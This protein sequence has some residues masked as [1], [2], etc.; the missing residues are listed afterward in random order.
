MS[1]RGTTALLALG[2]LLLFLV[3]MFGGRSGGGGGAEPARPTSVEPAGNGYSVARAWLEAQG[4]GVLS[5]RHSFDALERVA[6][7]LPADAGASL[8][9]L[10]LPGTMPIQTHE[11]AP[12]ERW[13]R[14]GNT[15][16]VVA[17][18]SDAPD[19]SE[20]SA[21]AP[22]YDLKAVTGLDFE[23]LRQRRARLDAQARGTAAG[24]DAA[25]DQAEPGQ[26][27]ADEIAGRRARALLARPRRLAAQ[28][29]GDGTLLTGVAAIVAETDYE[30]TPWSVR[31]PYDGLVLELARERASGEGVLWRRA[32]G[33]GE[34]LVSAWATPFANRGIGL[35]DNGRLFANL[36]ARAVGPRGVVLF[37]D[38][39]QGLAPVYDPEQLFGDRRLYAT[40]G[41]LVALWLLWVL[42][43]TRL[44][45]PRTAV[46]APRPADLLRAAGGF[47]MRVLATPAAARRLCEHF[48][49]RLPRPAADAAGDA[50]APP[51]DWL[52]R[53]PRLVDTDVRQ[54]RAWYGDALAGR[55]VPLGNLHNLLLRLERQ[56]T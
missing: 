3:L 23:S 17:A 27:P 21:G 37:D 25:P 6:P 10:T 18:L 38:G 41:I 44:R 30:R 15:L 8:L 56:M 40:L 20:A 43:A 46:P 48:F 35:G 42:G 54:L 47:Y 19:W 26:E 32:M 33:R 31:L 12:L 24:M 11:L 22:V 50:V 2:A 55:R 39:H 16:L 53:H 7:A 1:E 14:A 9:V 5:L 29:V 36:V 4:V 34:I 51:W 52:E 13:L 45:T 49:A 28:P